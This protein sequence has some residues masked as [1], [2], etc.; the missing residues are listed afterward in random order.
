MIEKVDSEPPKAVSEFTQ[1]QRWED[2]DGAV[3]KTGI[4]LPQL[5]EINTSWSMDIARE[6]LSYWK[7]DQ[8]ENLSE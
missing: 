8:K 7:H 4:L 5:A 2:D 1:I 6:C 3:F